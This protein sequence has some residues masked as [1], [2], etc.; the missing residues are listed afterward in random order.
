MTT[1]LTG[2][3]SLVRLALRRDRVRLP[4]WVVLLVVV[5]AVTP[6]SFAELFPTEAARA[7][8]AGGVAANPAL[9]AIQGPM[10]GTT[11]GALTAGRS[12]TIVAVLVALLS[13][14]TVIRHTR[15]EEEA[16]R[17]ELL[18]AGV[19]GRHAGLAAALAVVVGVDLLIA[20]GIAVALAAAGL[21]VAGSVLMGLA[22]GATGIVFAAVAAVAAQ[23]TEGA[24]A[25]TGI[26]LGLLG[27]AFL[28]RAAGDA[29]SAEWLSWLSPLGW[30]ARVQPF[31]GDR[32]WVLGLALGVAVVLTAVAFALSSRRDLAA[33]VLPARLGPADGRLGSPFG[34]AWR[35]HR[36]TL[37][38]WTAAF[39]LAGAAFGGIAQG[40]GSVLNSSPEV[41]EILRQ[42]GGG[43]GLVDVFLAA[44][45]G[46]LGLLASAYGI[47]AALR[48][49]SEET[50]GRAE[51]VLATSVGR[52]RW[53]SSHLLVA[54]LGPALVL[55][56]AGLAAGLVHG[57]AI[58]DVDGQV[59]RLVVG[60]AV[61]LPA[62]WVLVGIALA[63]FGVLPRA[64]V[65]AWAVLVVFLLFGQFGQLLS[66]P[67]W[68]LDISPFTHLPRT[69]GAA[70]D[71][72]PP[73]WM[74][75]I[76][77]ALVAVGFAGF[78]RR[79]VG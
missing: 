52:L 11:L 57:A 79:D 64:A 14:L 77:A 37:L 9:V 29:G 43:G 30:A 70:I 71:V 66:L 35:L 20:V 73:A 60:A 49:R 5:P 54:L 39:A 3:G 38:G 78:R 63:L 48:L 36:A 55:L 62:V 41:V 26:A 1:T 47:A 22:L 24:R 51:I 68:L 74:V 12:L 17:R 16:G 32:W 58:G 27:L 72:T 61:Q 19:V 2:T 28:A 59:P 50:D 8:Y 34:L 45:F 46:I 21:P 53:A 76:T 56:T 15:A 23:L 69:L 65:G 44:E 40:I 6:P 67:Q 18:G 75:V 42:L 7:A 4:I 31:T 33:G 13:A 25:A 10:Y